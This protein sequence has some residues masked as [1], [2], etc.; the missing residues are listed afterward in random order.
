MM[1]MMTLPVGMA[2]HNRDNGVMPWNQQAKAVIHFSVVLLLQV[3]YTAKKKTITHDCIVV[4]QSF[5][6]QICM[7]SMHTNVQ[8]HC[9]FFAI[10]FSHG[11]NGFTIFKDD[12]KET[13]ADDLLRKIKKVLKINYIFVL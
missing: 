4:N 12:V 7:Q 9:Y 3:P 6:L 10:I 2:L 1:M 11:F 8:S 13:S 5:V